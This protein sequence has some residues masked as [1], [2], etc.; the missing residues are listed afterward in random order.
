MPYTWGDEAYI[1]DDVQRDLRR[2]ALVAIVGLSEVSERSGD[3]LAQYP[4][5]LLYTI[6]Y[7]DGSSDYAF[8]ADLRPFS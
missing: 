6:E 5:G 2:G 4:H 1:R 7:E 8:E 3:F